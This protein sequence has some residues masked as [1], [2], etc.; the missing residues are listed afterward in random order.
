MLNDEICRLRD[1]LNKS[2]EEE[3]DYEIIYK[4]SVKL[5]KL[6]SEFYNIGTKKI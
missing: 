5:D 6:I 2:I 4:I 1:E 3:K